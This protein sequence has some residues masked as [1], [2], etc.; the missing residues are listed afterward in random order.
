M[1][2]AKFRSILGWSA[3]YN[4]ALLLFFAL[5]FLIAKEWIF[6]VWGYFFNVSYEQYEVFMLY[7]MAFWKVL[8][9]VFFIIP[10]LAIGKVQ[11]GIKE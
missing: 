9:F 6:D 8:I 7:S 5:F 2:I 1:T 4:M 3:V 10:Y 11:K